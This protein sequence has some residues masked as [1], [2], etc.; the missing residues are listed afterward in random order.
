MGAGFRGCRFHSDSSIGERGP[1]F[2]RRRHCW[3]LPRRSSRT[4]RLEKFR[5]TRFSM[6]FTRTN[7]SRPTPPL[8]PVSSAAAVSS[9]TSNSLEDAPLPTNFLKT[10][11]ST[12]PK[13]P[14]AATSSNSPSTSSS[15][16]SK[17]ISAARSRLDSTQKTSEFCQECGSSGPLRPLCCRNKSWRG[18]RTGLP[19]FSAAAGC[20]DGR[21]AGPVRIGRPC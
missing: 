9:K 14:T 15:N 4:A 6:P 2:P 18:R 13:P 11:P 3:V 8:L 19:V 16:P 20:S 12:R 1:Q 21:R 5:T 17:P 10:D 7:S